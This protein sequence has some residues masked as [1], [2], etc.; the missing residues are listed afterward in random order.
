[1]SDSSQTIKDFILWEHL[2]PMMHK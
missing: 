1:M 2:Q